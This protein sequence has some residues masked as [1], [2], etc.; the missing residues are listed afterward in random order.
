MKWILKYLKGTI[1]VGIVYRRDNNGSEITGFVDSDHASDLDDCRSLVGYVFTL[2]GGAV[3]WKSS[4]Q[5][6]IALSSTEAKYMVL[7]IV[8]KEEIWL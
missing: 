8:A 5:D 1:D 7:T 3:S 2:A 6:H 4:L